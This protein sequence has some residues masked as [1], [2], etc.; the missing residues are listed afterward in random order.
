MDLR[1]YYKNV[2]AIESTL[3]SPFVVVVSLETTDGGK[4]GVFSEVATLTAAK[5]IA[6]GR[7]RAATPKEVKEFHLLNEEKKMAA[8]RALALGRMQFVVLP[9]SDTVNGPKE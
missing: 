3:P 2:R 7:A 5:Q 9:P 8:E 6:E 4:P 1:A